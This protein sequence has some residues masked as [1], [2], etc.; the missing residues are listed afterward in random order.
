MAPGISENE[1]PSELASHWYVSLPGSMKSDAPFSLART[2]TVSP[3]AY[4]YVL[5]EPLDKDAE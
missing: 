1:E 3:T 4:T 5:E 2:I